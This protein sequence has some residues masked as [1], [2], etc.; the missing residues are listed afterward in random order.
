MRWS[1][2]DLMDLPEDLFPE[3]VEWLNETHASTSDID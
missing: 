3:L 1:Y 2:Q